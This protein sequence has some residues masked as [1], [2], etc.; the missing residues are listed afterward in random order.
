MASSFDLSRIR[1]ITHSCI[2]MQDSAGTVLYVDPFDLT[3]EPHDADAILITHAHYDH[4]SPEDIAR[5][6]R[7]DTVLVA[8]ASMASDAAQTG[9]A[10]VQT[11]QAGDRIELPGIAVEVVPAY[12]V[13][14]E[15][16]QFHP[17]ANG[18]VGYVVT[19]DGTRCYVAGDTDQ[20]PDNATVACEV[21]L[22]PIGGTYTMDAEQAA[23]FVNTLA[24]RIAIP[25]HYGSIVGTA[26]D[27]ERFAAH[28]DPNITCEILL[29]R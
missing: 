28:L 11:V 19:I 24:P 20:N 3:E 21:A 23:T 25:T 12:N 22:V 17:R 5:V 2:R 16:R 27:A 4:F 6:A 15:R 29:G 1:V 9:L 14:P 13:E 7:A 18:W 8:P 10:R 26:A